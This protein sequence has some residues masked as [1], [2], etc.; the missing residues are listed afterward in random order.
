MDET[1]VGIGIIVLLLL[2]AVAV[3]ISENKRRKLFLQQKLKNAWG[4]IPDREYAY[5]DFHHISPV[6]PPKE[7][8]MNFSL[9]AHY[10]E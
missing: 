10:L 1:V 6:S 4:Q 2:S 3:M 7:K 9:N 5:E 8:K